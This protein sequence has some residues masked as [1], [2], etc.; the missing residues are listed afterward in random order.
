[1]NLYEWNEQK[2]MSLAAFGMTYQSYSGT[3]IHLNLENAK[4]FA[5]WHRGLPL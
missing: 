5:L 4:I 2:L 3:I 1:M